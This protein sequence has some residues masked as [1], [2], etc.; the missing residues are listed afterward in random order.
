MIKHSSVY[1]LKNVIIL[2]QTSWISDWWESLNSYLHPSLLHEY[3]YFHKAFQDRLLCH[4]LFVYRFY[5]SEKN[6][7]IHM[8]RTTTKYLLLQVVSQLILL[9]S[10][11]LLNCQ[12]C[13]LLPKHSNLK[14]SC[15]L[16]RNTGERRLP[17][18]TLFSMQCCVCVFLFVSWDWLRPSVLMLGVVCTAINL[19]DIVQVLTNFRPPNRTRSCCFTQKH[20]KVQYFTNICVTASNLP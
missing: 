16:T 7:Y 1:A 15:I 17:S 3:P 13:C 9:S 5:G 11:F 12:M 14:T 19:Y 6:N 18:A 2:Q 4:H 8:V 10:C 20:S